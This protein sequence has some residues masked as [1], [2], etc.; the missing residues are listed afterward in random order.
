[1]A[2]VKPHFNDMAVR[3]FRILAYCD[4]TPIVDATNFKTMITARAKDW[5]KL[6]LEDQGECSHIIANAISSYNISCAK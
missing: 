4:E 3:W 5:S 1:M 2:Y 6:S